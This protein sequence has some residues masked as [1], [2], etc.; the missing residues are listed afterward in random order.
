MRARFLVAIGLIA[1]IAFTG[2]YDP[3]SV[4][5]PD[6]VLL[7]TATPE[8]I[9]ANGFSTSRI[10]AKI[11]HVGEPRRDDFVLDLRGD[12]VVNRSQGSG[13]QR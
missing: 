8:A 3:N 13:R 5:A 11:S 7:L 10:T 1:A 2:C 12:V 4:V 9:P 6:E